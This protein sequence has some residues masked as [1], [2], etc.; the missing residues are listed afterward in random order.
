VHCALNFLSRLFA[1][2]TCHIEIV[3]DIACSCH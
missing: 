2:F 1:V 3:G